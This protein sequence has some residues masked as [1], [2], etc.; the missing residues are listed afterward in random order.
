MVFVVNAGGYNPLIGGSVALHKLAHNLELAGEKAYLASA[1][2]NPD[3]LGEMLPEGYD[4]NELDNPVVI[5]GETMIGNY[6]KA[7][8]VVRWFLST[9]K[10]MG[11]DGIYQPSDMIVSYTEYYSRDYPD[12][13]LLT[14]YD[15]RYTDWGDDRLERKGICYSVRKGSKKIIKH[16]PGRDM[17]ID[18][19][20]SNREL[21]DHFNRHRMFVSYDHMTMLSVFAVLCGCDSVVV[22]AE[23]L[24][25]V[26]WRRMFPY[27]QYGIAYGENDLEYARATSQFVPDYLGELEKTSMY[28]TERFIKTA[29]ER[30]R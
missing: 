24:T 13:L 11:G 8:N 17:P 1:R 20:H 27:F 25:A 22:P 6:M 2:K 30:F 21:R 7:K 14:A 12:A 9:P 26:E 28:Q 19:Y 10:F 16:Y 3:W 23:D 15:W 18:G 29:K 4:V 5:Y